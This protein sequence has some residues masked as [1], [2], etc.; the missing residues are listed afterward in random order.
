MFDVDRT[1]TGKQGSSSQCPQ[2]EVF[3]GVVDDSYDG[4]SLMLSGL[5]QHVL[6][7]FCGKCYIGIVTAGDAGGPRSKERSVIL[8]QL[9]TERTLTDQWSGPDPV[10]SSLVTFAQDRKKQISVQGIVDWFRSQKNVTIAN[11]DVHFFDDRLDNVEPFTGTGFNAR[12]VSC[13]SRDSNLYWGHVIPMGLCGA[14]TAEVI[15]DTG[16]IVCP[17]E[18]AAQFRL[19]QSK[20][21]SARSPQTRTKAAMSIFIAVLS[22]LSIVILILLVVAQQ[23]PQGTAFKKRLSGWISGIVGRKYDK[24]ESFLPNDAKGKNA[25]A[26]H[27]VVFR[28]VDDERAVGA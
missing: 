5:G 12:Q 4:G 14:V 9:T 8:E 19:A 27:V 20:S 11:E 13:Q 18:D 6:D 1:L 22:V 28:G 7:T 10:T 3:P 23:N 17:C 15:K 26:P 25:V 24:R 21:A 2:D 16:V